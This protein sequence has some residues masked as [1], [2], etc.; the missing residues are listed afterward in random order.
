[1]SASD[2]Q[3]GYATAC[4]MVSELI[5]HKA[6]TW[7]PEGNAALLEFAEHVRNMTPSPAIT[8]A[9][10]SWRRKRNAPQAR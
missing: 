6:K 10:L 5:R 8:K 7:G 1:M 3:A 9:I 2:F 4:A